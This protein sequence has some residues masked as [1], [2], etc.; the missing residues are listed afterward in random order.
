[1]IHEAA[2]LE[3]GAKLLFTLNVRQRDLAVD[4]GLTLNAIP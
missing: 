1:M 3:L 2:A 4:A